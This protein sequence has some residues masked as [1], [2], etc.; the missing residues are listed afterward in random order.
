MFVKSSK[1]ILEWENLKSF[2][3]KVIG[4]WKDKI[5]FPNATDL[6]FQ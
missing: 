5:C 3:I 1:M 4:T 2:S 6:S